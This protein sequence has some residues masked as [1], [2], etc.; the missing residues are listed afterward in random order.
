M[1]YIDCLCFRNVE[2]E[3]NDKF[4]VEE[5]LDLTHPENNSKYFVAILVKSLC[6]LDKLP[7]A[8]EVCGYSIKLWQI[9]INLL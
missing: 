5:D 3:L 9:M 6:L 2:F 4:D 1:F 7:Y 8:I